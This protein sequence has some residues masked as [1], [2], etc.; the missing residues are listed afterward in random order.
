M[1]AVL[2]VQACV[3]DFEHIEVVVVADNHGV[4]FW[5]QLNLK[6]PLD[7]QEYIFIVDRVAVH[8]GD[9]RV[10][11]LGHNSIGPDQIALLDVRESGSDVVCSQRG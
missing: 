1:S 8:E 10:P 6:E 7:S 3:V 11:E 2:D 4:N 9:L 5:V